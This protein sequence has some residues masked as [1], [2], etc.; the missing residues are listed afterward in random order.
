MFLISPGGGCVA[1]SPFWLWQVSSSPNPGRATQHCAPPT[2]PQVKVSVPLSPALGG[3]LC[4][5]PLPGQA[6]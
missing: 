4:I 6:G 5:S 1:P 2:V 3:Q